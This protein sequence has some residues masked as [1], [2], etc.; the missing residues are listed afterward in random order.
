MKKALFLPVF[1]VFAVSSFA[2]DLPNR[3]VFIEGTA[4]RADHR[5]YFLR[6]FHDEAF[7]T[8]FPIAE[9]VNDAGYI[10][11]FNVSPNVD[12]QADDNYFVINIS[13][14]C[15]TDD[16]E[17]LNFDFFFTTLDE[18]Y[19]H[20]QPLFL[21]AVSYIPPFS[22][23]DLIIIQAV[24]NRWKNKWIYLRAS[25]DYPVTFYVL[26]GTGLWG[27]PPIAVFN[28]N[29]GEPNFSFSDQDH[30]IYALPGATVGLQFQLLNFF[31]IEGNFQ[32]SMGDTRDNNFINMAAGAEVKFPLKFLRNFMI[33]PYGTFVYHLKTSDIFYEF[34]PFA[35]GG[36]IQI[37][38]RGGRHG[39]FFVDIKYLFSLTESGMH[40]PYGELWPN[41]EVIYYKRHVIGLGIGYKIGIFNRR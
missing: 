13:L 6:N 3:R 32:I 12:R 2:S 30:K 34:P 15:N 8:G 41:P 22:E 23:D 26:Q 36:G 35:F 24:D 40:N 5:E 39:A 38:T 20:N 7:G 1:L 9:N 4:S 10:L 33:E 18:M 25:F 29:F 14:I 19:E 21:R 31:S 27:E 11:R 28:G 16:L 17:V 37:G